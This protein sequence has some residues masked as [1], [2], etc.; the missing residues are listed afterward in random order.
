MITAMSEWMYRLS[1]Q[2]YLW[3]QL[4]HIR[5][6]RY[7]E[8]RWSYFNRIGQFI[9]FISSFDYSNEWVN[10]SVLDIYKN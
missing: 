4:D 9:Q 7:H 3:W 1:H 10:I 2:I 8:Q 5:I 6:K